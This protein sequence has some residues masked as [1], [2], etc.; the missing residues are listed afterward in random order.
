MCIRY[1]FIF[2][3]DEYV[4]DNPMKDSNEWKSYQAKR[5]RMLQF[6]DEAIDFPLCTE[7][8]SSAYLKSKVCFIQII[9]L[10]LAVVSSFFLF[11]VANSKDNKRN[12]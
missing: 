12:L 10:L 4:S 9:L 7:E 11:R 2:D 6:S 1:R 8:L 3:F 5:R